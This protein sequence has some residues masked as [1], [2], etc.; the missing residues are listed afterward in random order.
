V[1]L[2]TRQGPSSL[3][4]VVGEV[5]S[6]HLD[7]IVHRISKHRHAV[8][9]DSP[10]S[11]FWIVMLANTSGDAYI[12]TF[13]PSGTFYMRRSEVQIKCLRNVLHTVRKSEYRTYKEQC[14]RSV[15]W[16]IEY[17]FV[18]RRALP[19]TSCNTE[20]RGSRFPLCESKSN[21]LAYM[22]PSTGG[23]LISIWLNY[24]F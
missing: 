23:L 19:T 13:V 3:I 7:Y 12:S 14:S 16:K 22:I 15:Q 24:M 17:Y 18:Q 11:I 6:L 20:P 8:S 1:G 9:P 2:R 10:L 4:P 5:T 21:L